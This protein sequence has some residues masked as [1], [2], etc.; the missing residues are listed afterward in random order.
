MYG[1]RPTLPA[2]GLLLSIGLV[3]LGLAGCNTKG[4]YPVS[5]QL[6]WDGKD[7]K[8]LT[9]LAG[10]EVTFTSQQLAKSYRGKIQD[11]GSFKI[12]G[13]SPGD[14][15]VTVTQPNPQPERPEK[16]KPIVDRKYEDPDK[17][18]LKATVTTDAEKNNFTFTLKPI[19]SK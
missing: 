19:K 7:H 3:V 6:E 8:P 17:S 2:W 1:S 9:E 10:F 18:D 4:T 12:E 15:K 13:A 5:G 14:Y 16:R 11:N